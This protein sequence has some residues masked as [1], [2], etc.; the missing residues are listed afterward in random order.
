MMA[1]ADDDVFSYVHVNLCIA[2][3]FFVVPQYC[4]HVW[5]DSQFSVKVHLSQFFTFPFPLNSQISHISDYT[6]C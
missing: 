4:K 2:D 6:D 3:T 1:K 5:A